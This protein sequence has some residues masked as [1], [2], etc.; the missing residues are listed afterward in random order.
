ML[1]IVGGSFEGIEKIIAK[2]KQGKTTMGFGAKPI[3]TKNAEFNTF[4]E[5]I[6]VDDLK[7]FG[8]IPE[9]LGRFPVIAPLKQL[10]VDAL[11]KILTEPKNAIIK[12][13]TELLKMD[14]VT[15]KFTDDALVAIANKAIERKTG[16]R[17]LRSII[18]DVLL[19][20]M[21]KLPDD[22]TCDSIT[23]TKEVV[24]NNAYAILTYNKKK[25]KQETD[26]S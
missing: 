5:D 22:E 17:S 26:L 4:I 18:D 8:M 6:K 1:F 16:A 20:Y 23:I 24:E 2:R 19:S 13:Y 10:N 21:Y 25:I 14:G 3:D 9:F 12:Q 7:K 11:I 15:L